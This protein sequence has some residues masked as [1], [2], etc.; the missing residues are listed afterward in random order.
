MSTN[1]TMVL[2]TQKSR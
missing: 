2:T 1:G